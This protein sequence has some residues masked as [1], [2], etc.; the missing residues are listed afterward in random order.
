MTASKTLTFRSS[1]PQKEL[2]LQYMR[3]FGSITPKEAYNQLCI[4]R[5]ASRISDL[6]KDGH[7]IVKEW[8]TSKNIYG[9]ESTYARYKLEE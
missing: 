5:L 6:K 3:D 9:I 4:M 8:E 2:V 1:V 7:K